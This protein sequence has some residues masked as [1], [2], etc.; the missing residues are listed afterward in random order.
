MSDWQ[1]HTDTH[2]DLDMGAAGNVEGFK[3]FTMPHGTIQVADAHYW[4]NQNQPQKV[5]TSSIVNWND[6]TGVRFQDP[7]A[8]QTLWD[9]WTKAH[10]DPNGAKENFRVS[11]KTKDGSDLEIWSLEG[12]LVVDVQRSEEHTSELQSR[13]YLV[14]R[15]LL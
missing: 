5:T 11:K 1:L 15:L 14:C 6:L 12:A 2:V 8:H 7:A 9:A 13:Q 10:D 3:S 4:N